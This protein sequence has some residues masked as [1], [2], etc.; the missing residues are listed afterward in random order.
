MIVIDIDR[1]TLQNL[2]NQLT[3]NMILYLEKPE[4][5]ELYSMIN[6]MLFRTKLKIPKEETERLLFYE[7]NLKGFIKVN[8]I[9]QINEPLRAVL[10][11]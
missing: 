1:E 8:D 4:I 5:V 7:N 9:S 11:V 10:T 2:N 6:N 3:G